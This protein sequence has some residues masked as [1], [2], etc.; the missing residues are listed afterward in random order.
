MS[1]NTTVVAS[2]LNAVVETWYDVRAR[3]CAEALAECT[4]GNARPK[5]MTTFSEVL[6]VKQY[7]INLA[8]YVFTVPCTLNGWQNLLDEVRSANLKEAIFVTQTYKE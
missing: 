3:L 1:D 5:T 6:L 4:Y 8:R 7:D 2:A